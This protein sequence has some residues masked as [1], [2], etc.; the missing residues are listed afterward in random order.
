MPP[1]TPPRQP[2]TAARDWFDCKTGQALAQQVQRQTI[3]EL[4]RVFGHSGLYLRPCATTSTSLSGNMLARVISLHRQDSGFAGDLRCLD[5]EFPVASASLALIYGVFVLETS[6][7]SHA[8]LAEMARMLKPE[9]AALILTLNP[10]SPY[11]ARWLWRGL[12]VLSAGNLRQKLQ[13][14]GL[15][16]S[17]QRTLGPFWSG[18][19]DEMAVAG[20]HTDPFA[21][22][23]AATLT[24]ARR[25][26]PAL[27]AM[28]HSSPGIRLRPG[29]STG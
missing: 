25:R 15:E 3:P 22:L 18:R 11:R 9:G 7:D 17:R 20:D 23:R 2:E 10:F 1:V 14:C 13:Q 4:T 6:N 27:N 16:V 29:V 12:R 28:R 5:H 19:S 21:P 24:I 26:D 8:L